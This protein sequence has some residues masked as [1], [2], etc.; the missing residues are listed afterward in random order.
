MEIK[1]PEAAEWY[2]RCRDGIGE[3]VYSVV[4]WSA[5]EA[6]YDDAAGVAI[7]KRAVPGIDDDAA[8]EIAEMARA[9]RLDAIQ[10][11]E[12]L[13]RATRTE[14]EDDR[15]AL[16]EE[17]RQIEEERSHGDGVGQDRARARG[18]GLNMA[19]AYGFSAGVYEQADHGWRLVQWSRHKTQAAAERAA[20]SYE[21]ECWASA[22]PAI[23]VYSTS[24]WWRAGD[25]P[26]V[27]VTRIPREEV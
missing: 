14:D 25:G 23:G 2:A 26:A 7:V 11:C 27:E 4:P 16:I 22:G 10:V 20:R 15:A 6:G 12:L 18:G 24:A 9:V 19:T 1:S 13:D 8:L 3:I 5:V 21:R 17:A